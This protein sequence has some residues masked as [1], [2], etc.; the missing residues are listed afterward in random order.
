MIIGVEFST[1]DG[2]PDKASAKAVAHAC[3]DRRMLLL[4]CGP[5]DNT[6][7]WIPPLMVSAEQIDQGLQIFGEALREV[8]G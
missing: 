2:K 1:L 5:W 8:L 7:R 6:I 3:L 4:T